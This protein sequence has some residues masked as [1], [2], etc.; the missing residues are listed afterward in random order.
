MQEFARNMWKNRAARMG[1]EITEPNVEEPI[2]P[3]KET[4]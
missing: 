2:D 1:L 3:Q 4:S